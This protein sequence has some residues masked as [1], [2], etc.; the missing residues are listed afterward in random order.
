M[1]SEKHLQKKKDIINTAF[2][3]WNK[4]CFYSTS[5]NDIAESLNITK[6]A[7]YRYFSAKK[8]LLNAMEQQIVDDY[9]K[10]SDRII[11]KMGTLSPDEAVESYVMNQISFFRKH[12]EYMTFLIS[13]VRLQEHEDKEFLNIIVK[14]SDFLQEKLSLPLSA[15]NY[16]LNLVV[17]YILLGDKG[18]TEKLTETICRIFKTGFGTELLKNPENSDLILKSARLSQYGDPDENKVLQAISEVVLEEGPQASLEKIAAKAG[19]TKSSLYFYFKNKKEMIIQ[20]INGQT[21]SFVDFYYG[22]LSSF[23]D[24][25]EQL[26]A[27]FVI[28]ASMTIEMPRTIPM[29]HWFITQGMA[30][31]FK[32]PTEFEHYRVF[33]E[34]AVNDRYLN[35]H[36]MTADRLLMLVNFCMTYE[37]NNI[38]RKP[39]SKENKYRLVYEMYELFTHGLEGKKEYKK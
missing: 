39:L 8:D 18:N 4:N 27:H 38:Q 29:I 13:K 3:V 5:L 10:N 37:I 35:T 21:E 31:N 30:E 19:M 34:N 22:K 36:G 1:K 14:Q 7:I 25:G 12:K 26:F 28:S 20:T 17:F 15:I 32:K 24:I 23:D 2:R 6:Q 33:F 9:K 11:N 16:I